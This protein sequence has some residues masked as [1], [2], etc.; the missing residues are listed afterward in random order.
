MRPKIQFTEENIRRLFGF[1][2][3]EGEEVERLKQYYFK[4]DT[5]EHVLADLPIRVLVGHK[6]VGKSALFRVAM[7]EQQE[8]GDLTILIKPDDVAEIG[9]KH[10]SL[11]LSIPKWKFG[12]TAIIAE[13]VL[14]QFGINDDSIKGKIIQSGMK[15][16]SLVTDT[17]TPL[18]KGKVKFSSSQLKLIEHFL[19]TQKIIVYIDDLDRGWQNR[20]E[21]VI[22][23]SSLLNA[24]RDLAYQN[25]GLAFKISLRSDV[26]AAIRFEDESSDKI[27]GS[28]IWHSYELHEIFVM[29]VIR[30]LTFFNESINEENLRKSGQR[31]LSYFLESIIAINFEGRGNWEKAPIHQVILSLIRK[32]P[33]D[34]VKL[35]SLAARK[36]YSDRSAIITTKHWELIF[37]QYSQG[38]I[39]DTIVEFK[40]E[41]LEIERL[42]FGMKPEKK[43]TKAADAF[44]FTSA[45][46]RLKLNKIIERGTFKFA[47]GRIATASDLA[48]FLYKINF[49]TARKTLENGTIQRKY[50]EENNYLSSTFVDFGYDW[51][52]HLA[53]RW[54]LQPD[55]L[56]NILAK[57]VRSK[58]ELQI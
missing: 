39:H 49:L 22:M 24:A 26:Y 8:R 51:E 56:E 50:F 33:R 18:L 57:L 4:N 10:E 52:V 21:G 11:V 5:F 40:S 34:I 32:R 45:E 20:K 48:Q 46:L 27:S 25:K 35:C 37:E 47:N 7:S 28:V 38:V 9:E 54:A 43:N 13:K 42:L 2:D 19:K 1:E 55:T 12:L 58:D 23:I 31:H 17:V 3:A 41:L 53:Y 15:V 44:V 6:G 30:V 29:L 16:V 36:A 14:A